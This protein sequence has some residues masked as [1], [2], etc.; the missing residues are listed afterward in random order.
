MTSKKHRKIM[1]G[2]AIH[3]FVIAVVCYAAFPVKSPE[4][5]IRLMYQTKVGN[6]LFNHQLHA[7]E[8]GFGL[9]CF[10]CHHHP[11]DDEM[12]LVACGQCHLSAPEEGVVPEYCLECHDAEEVEE[13]EHG[14][15]SEAIHDQCTQC[16]YEFGKGPLYQ[17]SLSPEEQN[18]LKTQPN[19][20]VDCSKCHI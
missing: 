9:D 11:Y 7:S 18:K 14:K 3:L 20:W 5:P 12:A 16:H 17:N 15:R 8:T 13:S 19:E 4:E 10:D 2:V 6:V 1:L